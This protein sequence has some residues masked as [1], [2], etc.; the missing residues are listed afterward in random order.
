MH[1]LPTS[2]H[3][4]TPTKCD[5]LESV[6]LGFKT[7][8][9][10]YSC[11]VSFACT[12][13]CSEAGIESFVCMTHRPIF[14]LCI[15][16]PD[17][18]GT[19]NIAQLSL[20]VGL[21]GDSRKGI[22]L[23]MVWTHVK[24]GKMIK[25]SIFFLSNKSCGII[26]CSSVHLYP[27]LHCMHLICLNSQ[28][29]QLSLWAG[30]FVLHVS[31]LVPLIGLEDVKQSITLKLYH[32]NHHLSYSKL[33]CYWMKIQLSLFLSDVVFLI[34]ETMIDPTYCV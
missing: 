9:C 7:G 27:K 2:K 31:V 23:W 17:L 26:G 29:T 18:N 1:Y 8:H 15:M 22:K 3:S 5:S 16:S 25:T 12:G 10:M 4:P 21:A 20:K 6:A 28:M 14:D 32:T 13:L 24:V 30:V 19:S 33:L 11:G 34:S